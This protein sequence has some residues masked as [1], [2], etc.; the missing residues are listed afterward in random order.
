MLTAEQQAT[1]RIMAGTLAQWLKDNRHKYDE[2]D[3][4]G[5]ANADEY[6]MYQI[7]TGF[8]RLYFECVQAGI[9]D[10]AAPNQPSLQ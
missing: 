4:D 2:V 6:G 5:L 7:S 3:K 9:I 10:P 8:M 1:L